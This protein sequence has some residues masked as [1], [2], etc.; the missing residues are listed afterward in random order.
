MY[1]NKHMDQPNQIIEQA[2]E[3]EQ[4]EIE[5]TIKKQKLRRELRQ[6]FINMQFNALRESLQA[7]RKN[8]MLEG[9]TDETSPPIQQCFS[10]FSQALA[11]ARNLKVLDLSNMDINPL[12][13]IELGQ[14]IQANSSLR[15][16]NLSGC[17]MNSFCIQYIF[18]SISNHKTLQSINLFN[19]QGFT[20]DLMNDFSQFVFKGK[21]HLKKIKL[22]HCNISSTAL[23]YL[24]RNIKYSKTI[25]QIDLSMMHFNTEA[26]TS[27]AIALQHY[28]GKK[29]L[30][31]LNMSYTLLGDQGLLTLAERVNWNMR[32][33]NLKELILRNN[34]IKQDTDVPQLET[35][36]R[37]INNLQ[38][39]DLSNNLI[40]EFSCQD[41]LNRS[42]YEINLSRNLFKVIPNNFFFNTLVVNL[43]NNQI[44]SQG[45]FQ[46]SSILRQNPRWIELNLSNNKLRSEGFNSLIFGLRDN[47]MLK[48]LIVANN[49]LD[50][51]ALICYMINHEQVYFEHLDISYNQIR[52]AM[53][54]YLLKEIKSGYLRCFRCASLIKE[55]EIKRQ[56]INPLLPR[57]EETQFKF[58]QEPFQLTS[59]NL[60]ELDF[61]G[62]PDMFPTVVKSLA[63]YFN[64]IEVL[65]LSS[66]AP[67]NKDDVEKLI[68]L[69]QKSTT[70]HDLSLRDLNLGNLP[71]DSIKRLSE[72]L[73]N[74]SV[75][76]LNLSKNRL[77]K[78][79]QHLFH[80]H[81][82]RLGWNYR[83]E[84]L[85]ISQ[86]L[87]ESQHAQYIEIILSQ[88][89]NL[90]DLN[91]SRNSLNFHVLQSINRTISS[92]RSIKRLNLSKTKLSADDL[93]IV[94]QTMGFENLQELNLSNNMK[95]NKLKSFFHQCSTQKINFLQLSQIYMDSSNFQ[96]S[97]QVISQQK[98][99]LRGIELNQVIFQR[100]GFIEFYNELRSLK[101][102]EYLAVNYNPALN[103]ELEFIGDKLSVLKNVTILKLNQISFSEKFLFSLSN[104]LKSNDCNLVTLDFSKNKFT[105][106]FLNILCDG[107][108]GNN[109]LQTLSLNDCKLGYLDLNL[110]G[111]SLGYSQT[112]YSIELSNNKLELLQSLCR[113]FYQKYRNQQHLEVDLSFNPLSKN[114]L[115]Q[116]LEPNHYLNMK[117]LQLK[118]L[119]LNG[120]NLKKEY[121]QNVIESQIR[122][123]NQFAFQ[124]IMSL[125]LNGND[126]EDLVA[127][128]IQEILAKNTSIKE[129]DLSSNKF[130]S[131]GMELIFK[132][133]LINQSIKTLNI[134]YNELDDALV[135]F[136]SPYFLNNQ[137]Q[138]LEF[139]ILRKN[140][141]SFVGSRQL[142]KIL[143]Y[144]SN[145]FIDNN[146]TECDDESAVIIIQQYARIG[147]KYRLQISN[148][149]K[150]LTEIQI[151]K[152]S[153]TDKFCESL[154][155]IYPQLQFIEIIDLSDNPFITMY[156]KVYLFIHLFDQ[157][158]GKH[159]IK[160]L[161]VTDYQ[162]QRKLFDDGLLRYC[163]LRLRNF[164]Y[165]PHEQVYKIGS[166]Q[167]YHTDHS[168]EIEKEM[169]QIIG[170]LCGLWIIHKINKVLTFL[171]MMD[172]PQFIVST[173]FIGKFRKN[174]INVK[175]MVIMFL[176]LSITVAQ[177]GYLK[178]MSNEQIDVYSQMQYFKEKCFEVNYN[179]C[180]EVTEKHKTDD[181][182][183]F[184]III[185]V[186]FF[187]EL[188][189]LVISITVRAKV[190]PAF[191]IV[192]PKLLQ[193]LHQK[194][195]HQRE[196][197]YMFQSMIGKI[198]ALPEKMILFY[199]WSLR[200]I[201]SESNN[202]LNFDSLYYM[203]IF[204]VVLKY[205]E[206]IVIWVYN[207]FLCL[208]LDPASDQAKYLSQIQKTLQLQ[209]YYILN[210]ILISICPQDGVYLNKSI[211]INYQ[212][213]YETYRLIVFDVTQII[214]LS[215]FY[216]EYNYLIST[217]F[218]NY[219]VLGY[220]DIWVMVGILKATLSIF[221]SMFNILTLRPAVVKQHGFNQ[222]LAIKRFYENRS[223]F[224]KPSNIKIDYVYERLIEI[225]RLRHE[226]NKRNKKTKAIDDQ[227]IKKRRMDEIQEA[228]DEDIDEPFV[229]SEK[230]SLFSS[231]SHEVPEAQDDIAPVLN[232]KINTKGN[233]R[234][235]I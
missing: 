148:I 156:G 158:F 34:R 46:I 42:L 9:F 186:S 21:N 189:Q 188:I 203:I 141:F 27:L 153:L 149:P 38:R 175:I 11:N 124:S 75:K 184:I 176:V 122:F 192:H 126:L 131:E 116:L 78:C 44:E 81:H 190:Q 71:T 89:K 2:E 70:L 13:A 50:G 206:L 47:R 199:A 93:L 69:L 234:F 204:F 135:N 88:F 5:L 104:F 25:T 55:E 110:L 181:M 232:L 160:A 23:S 30:E 63:E 26:L 165:P 72:A 6:I 201:N 169:K 83:I 173:L 207:T 125:Q 52:Y 214:I 108:Y 77:Y 231:M 168:N 222:A 146:W 86:N 164:L 58:S 162:E 161:Y 113:G 132:G 221:F 37:K 151:Y 150:F 138:S 144:Q 147:Q 105:Q 212:I 12:L 167:I 80:F 142:T 159:S 210:D 20:I 152:S 123:G 170:N 106:Q 61:H 209:N 202:K 191:Q 76:Y 133:M 235:V 79:I 111:A 74:S 117:C 82:S 85:D 187:V 73:F 213:I 233:Y 10:F 166:N 185:F 121:F 51:E 7:I 109:S 136:I 29:V 180:L 17:K 114:G 115:I 62:N 36:L 8:K 120:C 103:Q 48:K 59:F 60:R 182:M 54:F 96:N 223:Q 225:D 218:N 64:K 40:F 230:Q 224:V 154:A 229:E 226:S 118:F 4:M 15:E 194:F 57:P 91:I 98:K 119:N 130:K 53:V 16:L 183:I 179:N 211:K 84:S 18:S 45:A 174:N 112:I 197:F 56:D 95:T 208:T 39:L 128:E 228:G 195:P 177:L 139:L 134:S 205:V 172:P 65:D 107:I 171:D 220:L 97:L 35:F 127:N 14:G 31:Y 28:K 41:L 163:C 87:L 99:F 155:Q 178:I 67:I 68:K 198:G 3:N 157:S 94:A 24:L 140:H 49:S 193:Y 200:N 216:S 1:R 129:L 196:I 33:I 219:D 227:E 101:S 90:T 19:N 145:L 102:L 143:A 43:Q 215:M 100:G 66:C 22:T 92:N 32:K 217:K 137:L